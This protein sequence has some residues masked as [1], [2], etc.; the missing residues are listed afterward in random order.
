[1]GAF[2]TRQRRKFWAGGLRMADDE[3][4]FVLTTE[5]ERGTLRF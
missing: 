2:N 4:G 5:A 3:G 1:V